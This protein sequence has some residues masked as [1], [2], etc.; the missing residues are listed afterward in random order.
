[1]QSWQ[2][3]LG[4]TTP[5]GWP[6]LRMRLQGTLYLKE[7]TNFPTVSKKVSSSGTR[8]VCNPRGYVFRGKAENPEFNPEL[9]VEI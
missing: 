6:K 9:V 8:V 1:M 3:W 7:F 2:K 5:H 4:L